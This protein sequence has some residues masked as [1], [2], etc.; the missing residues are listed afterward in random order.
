MIC[1]PKIRGELNSCAKKCNVPT[2]TVITEWRE[3]FERGGKDKDLNFFSFYFV[4]S[5]RSTTTKGRTTKSFSFFANLPS[6]FR[7]SDVGLG[8]DVWHICHIRVI[9]GWWC[10]CLSTACCW[11]ERKRG[12]RQRVGQAKSLENEVTE[13][14]KAARSKSS[15]R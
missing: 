3:A 1:R 8:K 10:T 11:P 7:I 13:E 12:M 9:P 6:R 14:Y 15:S 5:L 2:T 4:L